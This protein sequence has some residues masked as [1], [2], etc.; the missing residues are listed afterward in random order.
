MLAT[1]F[2]IEARA[3][4]GYRLKYCMRWQIFFNSLDQLGN[5][6]R[7]REKWMPLNAKA[8][9]CLRFRDECG[10]KDYRRSLQI[11]IGLD[12]CRYLAAIGLWHHYVQQDHV[13]PKIPGAL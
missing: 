7:L 13:R 10:E 9:L 2:E 1:S 11:R 6:N 4:L 12:L 8:G 5:T 3:I